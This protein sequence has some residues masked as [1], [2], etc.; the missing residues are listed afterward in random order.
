M[1]EKILQNLWYGTF[2]YSIYEKFSTKPL[3]RNLFGHDLEKVHY[4]TL[5]T[6]PSYEQGEKWL[7]R[8]FYQSYDSRSNNHQLFDGSD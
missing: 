2:F 8:N 1:A 4:E 7:L 5:R 3:V 6:K